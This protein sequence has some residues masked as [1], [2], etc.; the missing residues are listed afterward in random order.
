MYHKKGRWI[1]S[2][3]CDGQSV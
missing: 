1:K 2:S 3:V